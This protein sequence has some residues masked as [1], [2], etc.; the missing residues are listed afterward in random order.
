MSLCTLA[1]VKT[2]LG[3]STEDEDALVQS[4]I[5]L[6]SE[7]FAL[8]IGRFDRA[9]GAG[10]LIEK[11]EDRAEK[12]RGGEQIVD[13]AGFPLAHDTETGAPLI[14]VQEAYVLGDLAAADA[15]EI[16]VDYEVAEDFGNIWRLTSGRDLGRPFADWVRVVYSGGWWPPDVAEPDA[17][18][19]TLLAVIRD[20]A[21]EQAR[22]MVA[23]KDH[24]G[25][26]SFHVGTATIDMVE[27][28]LLPSAKSVLDRFRGPGIG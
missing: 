5:D 6:A 26:R 15:L 19:A 20:A 18:W 21:A 7:W 9:A 11:F 10:S 8:Y 16:N 22:H 4:K 25:Q 3:W 17:R 13:L 2:L 1:D 28:E 27:Q 12:H 23:Q 14:V 24:V